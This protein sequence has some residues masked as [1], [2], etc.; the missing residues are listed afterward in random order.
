MNG[1]TQTALS[2]LHGYRCD[3]RTFPLGF[4]L[5]LPIVTDQ[6]ESAP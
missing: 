2:H 3:K 1:C 6:D 4:E 5:S